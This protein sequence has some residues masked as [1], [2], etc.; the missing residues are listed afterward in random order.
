[1]L[2]GRTAIE[3]IE[4]KLVLQMYHLEENSVSLLLY[5]PE[6]FPQQ[7]EKISLR[8]GDMQSRLTVDAGAKYR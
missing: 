2:L 5:S 3:E 6:V 4:T 1:M 7:E 8:W